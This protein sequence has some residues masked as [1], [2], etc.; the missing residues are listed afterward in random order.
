MCAAA[1]FSQETSGCALAHIEVR[2]S[3]REERRDWPRSAR[4]D[5]FTIGCANCCLIGVRADR[6]LQAKS[7]FFPEIL[8]Y[9]QPDP[10]EAADAF[11]TQGVF[12]PARQLHRASRVA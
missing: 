10:F 1:G 2:R 4:I 5:T 3:N 11:R 12:R 9:A 8:S 6:H 7:D